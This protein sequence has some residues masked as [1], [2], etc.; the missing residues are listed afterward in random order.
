MEMKSQTKDKDQ[1]IADLKKLFSTNVSKKSD[2]QIK[3]SLTI[4]RFRKS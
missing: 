2:S 4:C 3:D 1:F